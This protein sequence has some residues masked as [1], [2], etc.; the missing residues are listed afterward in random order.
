MDVAK[1][2]AQGFLKLFVLPALTFFLLPLGAVGFAAY[3]VSK[4]EGP[5]RVPFLWAERLALCSAGLGLFAFLFIGVLGLIAYR[6]ARSQ[7]WAVMVGWRGLMAIIV[8][9]SVLQGLLAVWLSY[10]V[11]ALL[12]NVFAPKLMVLAGFLAVLLVAAVMRAVFR[13]PPPFPALEAEVIAE[14]D[15]PEIWAR[16]RELAARLGTEPPGAIVAGIDDNF[17][18][19]ELPLR[20]TTGQSLEGRVLYLSLPLMRVLSQSEADAVFSHELAHFRAGDTE[21]LAKLSP[22]LVRHEQYWMTLMEG[23]VTRPAAHVMLLFRS[24]FVLALKK[25]QRRRELAAD[26]EAAK[27]TSADDL[28][29]ALLKVAGY[30]SFRHHTENELFDQHKVHATDLGLRARIDAGLPAHVATQR[31]LEQVKTLRVP[32]PFDS[33]PPL[34]ERFSNVGSAVRLEDAPRIF[35]TRPQKT[36][37]DEVLTGAAIE[38]RLW[39][40]YEA[41]FKRNHELSLAYRYLPATEEERQ[42]VVRFFP[43]V[44]FPSKDGFV[45]LTYLGI[46]LLDGEQIEFAD[47]HSVAIE[48]AMMLITYGAGS[49]T[50]KVNLDELKAFAEPFKQTFAQYWR[51]G[52]AAR[53]SRGPRH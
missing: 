53:E 15:A 46:V 4:I 41:R 51:R 12:V 2:L 18:V 17:F 38:L 5:S 16:V 10:W 35:E 20:L 19:T 14:S 50:T 6:S 36:W 30:S 24:A 22:E 40:A 47:M 42:L 11:T 45:G 48:D 37:A 29:R 9:E 25:E 26:T 21:A 43:S 39:T 7:Y 23:G 31:F 44:R 34:D 27:L 28:G 32:H 8:I 3:G 1:A 13:L 52:R 49:K 33:H